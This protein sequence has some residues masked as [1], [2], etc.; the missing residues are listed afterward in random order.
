[1]KKY[2]GIDLGTTTNWD[3]VDIALAHIRQLYFQGRPGSGKTYTALHRALNGRRAYSI[4]MTPDMPSAEL[5]G[6]YIPQKGE[7]VWHDGPA[8]RA[9]REGG[10]LIINEITNASADCMAFLYPILEDLSTATI[11][12]PTK[13]TITA[14]E[15][16]QVVATDNRP[17][18][19]LEEALQSRFTPFLCDEPHPD[20]IKTIPQEYRDVVLSSIASD[21]PESRYSLR[22][23]LKFLDL[24]SKVG[25]PTAARLIFK[26]NGVDMT[27]AVAVESNEIET[28]SVSLEF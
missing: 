9:M 1:M 23:W 2:Y 19:Y 8:V 24:K 28:P 7:L 26:G 27:R 12:L 20:V 11:T 25:A 15:M 13:E 21:E 14:H 16:F 17:F 5:R 3:D 22:H 6:H 4:T 10:R 18:D